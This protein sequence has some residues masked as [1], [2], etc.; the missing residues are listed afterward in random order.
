M[1][2]GCLAPTAIG[3][4]VSTQNACCDGQVQ[5]CQKLESQAARC[6]NK[7]VA[8]IMDAMGDAI[9]LLTKFIKGNMGNPFLEV[10]AVALKVIKAI[11][12][13]IAAFAKMMPGRR[14]RRKGSK[15]GMQKGMSDGMRLHNTRQ[16]Q[17]G[18]RIQGKAMVQMNEQDPDKQEEVLGSSAGR[19]GGRGGTGASFVAGRSASANRAGNDELSDLGDSSSNQIGSLDGRRGGRSASSGGMRFEFSSANRAGGQMSRPS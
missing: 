18:M 13:V 19:R 7:Y 3:I 8:N 17:N 6:G 15:K 2:E 5:D 9:G 4:A 12:K 1:E 10:K 16:L 11:K 14:R